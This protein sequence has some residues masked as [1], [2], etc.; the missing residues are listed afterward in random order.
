MA[1][2][3]DE[4]AANWDAENATNEYADKAFESL[5]K[6]VDL[7]G[8]HILDFG[9]GTGLLSQRMSPVAKDIVAL[10]SS[11]A[12]IEQLDMKELANVEPVVDILSRGLVAM[13]PA[14]RAQF[15]LVVASSVCSFLPSY[16]DTADIVFSLLDEGSYFVHWD[17]LSDKDKDEVGGMTIA[18]AQQV[19]SSVGFSEVV[20]TTPFDI[21]T[22]D[23]TLKV[24]MAVAKK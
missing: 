9:C 13:H 24:L 4:V 10:D 21:E 2:S 5:Q 1:N 14:F 19:L 18:H 16:S 12:M 7:K 15:D 23:G 11:E 3:W 20:V 8:M 22:P 17:W 6:V